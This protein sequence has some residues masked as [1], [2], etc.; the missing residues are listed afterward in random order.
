MSLFSRRPESP[1]EEVAAEQQL[2]E[3]TEDVGWQEF[4]KEA[5]REYSASPLLPIRP[6]ARFGRRRD[7]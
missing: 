5:D 2:D 7:T 1:E 3:A 4:D 6:L